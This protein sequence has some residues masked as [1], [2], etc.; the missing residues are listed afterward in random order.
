MKKLLF[1]LL[2]ILSISTLRAQTDRA[3]VLTNLERNQQ[4]VQASGTTAVLK[5]SSRLFKSEDDLTSVILVIPSGATVNI[6]SSDSTYFRVQYEDNEGYILRRHVEIVN[7]PSTPVASVRPE[8]QPQYQPD[9]R[10]AAPAPSQNQPE[11]RL[12]YFSSKY[13]ERIARLIDA[14]KIW[15][16][17]STEM[18]TDSWGNPLKINRIFRGNTTREEWKYKN[19]WL[20]FENDLLIEWGPVK[21]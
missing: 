7:N 20:Y 1:Y 2:L 5:S 17:M 6:I 10:Q 16:G 21:K 3:G 11:D 14:G 9:T 15:K 13:G 8:T 12:G 18:V 4:S 19:T